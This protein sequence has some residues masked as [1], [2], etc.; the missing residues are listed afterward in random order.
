MHET[1]EALENTVDAVNLGDA[2]NLILVGELVPKGNVLGHLPS[3][4]VHMMGRHREAKV[5]A[6]W[7]SETD[8]EGR[9]R[10]VAGTAVL[11]AGI[12]S[13]AE[14]PGEESPF[15]R[16][17]LREL[18]AA[19]CEPRDVEVCV[20]DGAEWIRRMFDDWFPDAVK[21][22]DYYHAAALHGSRAGGGLGAI[23]ARP[24]PSGNGFAPARTWTTM[25]P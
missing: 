3:W 11:F 23:R 5:G 14:T 17:L 16:R 24:R 20:G 2:V 4:E 18:A 7:V 6:L 19:G 12:E 13:A 25:A 8:A 15:E 21:I 10:M 1:E 22:V 9:P